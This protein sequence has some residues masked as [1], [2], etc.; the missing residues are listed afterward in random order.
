MLAPI[1]RVVLRVLG[2]NWNKSYITTKENGSV[3]G[4]NVASNQKLRKAMRSVLIYFV[5]VAL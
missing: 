1:T 5:R 4:R 3:Y 2:N